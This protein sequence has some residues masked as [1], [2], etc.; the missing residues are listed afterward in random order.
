MDYQLHNKVALVS[1]STAGIGYAIATML[2]GE[3]ATVIINGRNAERVERAIVGIRSV[4]PT[5]NLIGV[6]ADLSTSDG[7]DLLISKVP[8]VDILVN[9]LG[10]YAVKAFVDISDEEWI[11]MFNVN[12]MS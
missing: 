5:S 10:M 1:A 9:N 12:V 11:Q 4:H 7:V 3:G 2:A 6:P 8:K